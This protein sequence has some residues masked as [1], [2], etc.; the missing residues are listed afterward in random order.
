MAE[1]RR[2]IRPNALG[3]IPS[4]AAVSSDLLTQVIGGLLARGLDLTG[5][6]T[7]PL[8]RRLETRIALLGLD[9]AVYRARLDADPAEYGALLDALAVNV[10]GV[11]SATTWSASAAST[12]ATF[13]SV[14]VIFNDLASLQDGV[15]LS[16]TVTVTS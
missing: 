7:A 9:E 14:T 16:V 3:A 4:V 11:S 1:H 13:T 8:R 12:G 2:S 5:Y 10:S 15:P 6:R